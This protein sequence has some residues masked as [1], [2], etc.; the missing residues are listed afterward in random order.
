MAVEKA[1]RLGVALDALPLAELKKIEPKLSKEVY[2]VLSLEASV[3][4]RQSEG[5]T[6]PN[7]VAEQVAYWK[8]KLKEQRT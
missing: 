2:K 5:G 7:R 3:R 4:A 1:E 6:A 8:A